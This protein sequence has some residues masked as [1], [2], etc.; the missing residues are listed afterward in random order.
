MNFIF[1]VCIFILITHTISTLEERIFPMKKLTTAA[2]DQAVQDGIV[3]M[4]Q[5]LLQWK[6]PR[7]DIALTLLTAEELLVRL[8]RNAKDGA[9]IT[10]KL[11]RFLD[12]V[13]IHVNCPGVPFDA[14]D[15][16]EQ[17]GLDEDWAPDE[18]LV[19][20]NLVRRVCGEQFH[21]TNRNGV[22]L[23]SIAVKASSYKKLF[24][25]LSAL[26]LG[27]LFG[28]LLKLLPAEW[29]KLLTS[30]LLSPIST[31]FLNALKMIVGPLVLFSIA[32]SIAEF[33]NLKSLG[34]IA[35]KVMGFYCLTSLLAIAVG[36]LV[37]QV[38]PIG[39]PAMKDMID[40][41]VAAATVSG[42]SQVSLSIRDTI[43]NII[44][45]NPITP[46]QNGDM[47]QIIFIAALLGVGTALLSDSGAPV[48]KALKTANDLFSRITG[49]II[50]F[51][52]IAVFCSMAK[53]ICGMEISNLLKVAA[54]IPVC[55]VGHF[56]MILVYLVLLVL[57][58][59]I[60]PFTFV[61]KFIPVM[62]SAFSTSSS[63]VVMPMSMEYCEKKLGVSP[64]IAS[65]SIPLGA[66]VNMD[67]SC[68]TLIITALFAARIFELPITQPV[69]LSIVITIMALSIGAPGI[70]GGNLIC[71]SVL[72][73]TIG[74]P[75]ETV[76]LVMGIY[77]LVGMSQVMTNVTGD[78]VVTTIVAKQEKA[79]DLKTFN[80]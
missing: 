8:V 37:Y 29:S 21:I 10:I 20:Q 48:Q 66:T 24:E 27:L 36:Y 57:F 53:M 58:A 60:N 47:L 41:S 79:L 2:T 49:I 50:G 30:N 75:A 59:R 70:P 35:G 17:M 33:D 26:G 39:T 77:S 7:K 63:N 38:F 78:A 54:W 25:I 55:Y 22:N 45:N 44:P 15:L 69:L 14:S 13:N 65:F 73:P 5:T 62:V 31:M 56:S 4:E 12:A 80:E 52:P 34:K 9:Q 18:Q 19:V 1:G 64:K 51:M 61:R 68:I 67:G 72:L 76:S 23:C 16:E 3:F 6:V 42:S 43:I 32:S 71:I 28:F 40:S 11:H 46:F 74:I